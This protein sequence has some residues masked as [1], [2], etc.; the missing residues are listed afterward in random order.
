MNQIPNKI[1]TAQFLTALIKISHRIPLMLFYLFKMLYISNTK[2]YSWGKIIEIKAKQFPSKI[3]LKGNREL[4]Y[5]NLNEESNRIARK[6]FAL[7]IRK[8]DVIPILLENCVEYPIVV[9]AI[10]KIGA[11]SSL[12]PTSLKEDNLEQILSSF[13]F[14]VAIIS[15]RFENYKSLFLKD[16][17]ITLLWI[18]EKSKWEASKSYLYEDL[19]SYSFENIPETKN[20][21]SNAP[22]T[23]I[24]TSGTTG[25]GLKTAVIPHR[26][27]IR[28]TIWFGKIVQ[29]SKSI[30]TVYS[31][32]P[33]YHSSSLKMGWPVAV[34]GGSSFVMENSFSV[35]QFFDR[36][37]KWNVTLL[38]Y[39]G[40]ILTYLLQYPSSEKDQ[41]HTIKKILGNGLRV[42]IWDQFK[43]RFGISHVYEMYGAS[44][45]PQTFSN[46]LNID[47]S[48]GLDLEPYS[49]VQINYQSDE[50][51]RDRNGIAKKVAVGEKGLL[52]FKASKKKQFL[53]G[54]LNK[55]DTEEKLVHSIIKED[56]IWFNTG[57]IVQSLGFRHVRFIDRM[58]D[59]YRWKGENGSTRE[60]E[61]IVYK[62]TEV[63][64]AIAYGVKVPNSDG[65]AG[66]VGI[67]T[68]DI[69]TVL[70]FLENEF[71]KTLSSQLIPRFI[72]RIENIAITDSFKSKKKT[73]Q[74]EGINPMVI[75]DDIFIWN[76]EKSE[77][78]L[79]TQDLYKDLEMGRF[80][81]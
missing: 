54:Y 4:T 46:I 19:N 29:S 64:Q 9:T 70:S 22:Y 17:T 30:D 11:I 73:F 33:F 40:E 3:A 78:L 62:C 26:R 81:I 24:F 75:K 36:I 31:P 16:S 63:Q 44:E 66:M 1:G 7:G 80:H 6:L 42:E 56:D 15:E 32:L 13:S 50:I 55:Q 20:I 28:S 48:V 5:R 25:K 58:G 38:I 67:V 60:V 79:L 14:K 21:E 68:K 52:L 8:G 69:T 27:L 47:Y 18:C 34:A 37:K 12:I 77:Y 49:I 65:R 39:V 35:S 59:T 41:N 43:Q 51:V 23:H 45:S 61:S 53:G 71:L 10:A 2:Y 57:D 76:F 74:F 72:R